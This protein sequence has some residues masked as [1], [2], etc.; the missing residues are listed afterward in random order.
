MITDIPVGIQIEHLHHKS[1]ERY[2]HTRVIY[3]AQA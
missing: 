1:L 3:E 2:Q